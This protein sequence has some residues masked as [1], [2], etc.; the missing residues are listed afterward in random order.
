[1]KFGTIYADPP[2]GYAP[3]TK[4]PDE[5]SMQSGYSTTVEYPALSTDD[6]CGLSVSALAAD[7]AVLALWATVAFV[8]DALKVMRAW[9]FEYKT[10]L[11][12]TKTIKTDPAK[13]HGGGVGSWFRG[14]VEYLFIGTR[15]NTRAVFTRRPGAYLDVISGLPD[16]LLAPKLGHSEKPECFYELLEAPHYSGRSGQERGRYFPAPRLE[17]FARTHR[18]DERTGEYVSLRGPRPGWT[19]IGFD[20]DGPVGFGEDIRDGLVRI[21]RPRRTVA[22]SSPEAA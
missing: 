13:V 7:D 16:G 21:S 2:W 4:T 10:S 8:P 9:G 20:F 3:P 19:Q 14:A 15:P 5:G 12:W 18:W 6:L 1:M 22:I 11:S 17:L